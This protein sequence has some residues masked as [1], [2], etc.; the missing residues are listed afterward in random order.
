MRCGG[1]YG[2]VRARYDATRRGCDAVRA[3]KGCGAVE[4]T[5]RYRCD[6]DAIRCGCGAVSAIQ[7]AVRW[8]LRR[9]TDTIRCDTARMRRSTCDKGCGAVN[10]TALYICGAGA[11]RCDTARVRRSTGDTRCGAVETTARYGRDTTR[12]GA[13]AT[14]YVRLGDAARWRLRRGTDAMRMRYGAIR[15][16]CGAVSAIQDAVR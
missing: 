16:G 12:H 6:A 4:I 15:C 13:G 1:D 11:I 9:C 5:T 7:D 8:K 2:A 3:I 14:Q 10:I